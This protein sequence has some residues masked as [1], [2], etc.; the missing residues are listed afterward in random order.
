[1]ERSPHLYTDISF[2]Y[3]KQLK[4]GLRRLSK[5]PEKY[6]SF[7]SK[8]QDRILFG[9]DMVV[10]KTPEKD[11]EWLTTVAQVYRDFLEKEEYT[12]FAMPDAT[13]RGLH[14]QCTVLEKIC[15]TNAMRLLSSQRQD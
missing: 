4:A 13:L 9:T 11:V 12:F 14:L 6:R 8:H 2:G 5:D 7:I 10:M 3:I 15:R 1:M